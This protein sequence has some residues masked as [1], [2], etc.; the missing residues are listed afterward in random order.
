MIAGTN[1]SLIQLVTK[2]P[3]FTQR[4]PLFAIRNYEMMAEPERRM[5]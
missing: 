1:G 4:A 2:Q 3:N 5:V